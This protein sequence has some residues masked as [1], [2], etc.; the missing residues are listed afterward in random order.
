MG[1]VRGT[2]HALRRSALLF[3]QPPRVLE[4]KWGTSL[5]VYDSSTHT[6]SGHTRNSIHK[7]P[8]ACFRARR[9]GV[10][11]AMLPPRSLDQ[12][13]PRYARCHVSVA[14]LR[15]VSRRRVSPPAATRHFRLTE[16]SPPFQIEGNRYMSVSSP[17]HR[18]TCCPTQR[19]VTFSRGSSSM[20]VSRMYQ[21]R[22]VQTVS[23]RSRFQQ[24]LSVFP[25]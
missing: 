4:T 21:F 19:I 16:F 12:S 14:S 7:R 18:K 2:D 20:D 23:S 6:T 13:C 5:R 15:V 9:G 17:S 22:F 11:P 1:E 24:F 8:R 3:P 10:Y 25:R